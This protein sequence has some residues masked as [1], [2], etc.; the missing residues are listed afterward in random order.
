MRIR[1]M[2]GAINPAFSFRRFSGDQD[3]PDRTDSTNPSTTNILFPSAECVTSRCRD[4]K[5]NRNYPIKCDAITSGPD[6]SIDCR[7]SK[8][9]GVRLDWNKMKIKAES[10]VARCSYRSVVRNW[11]LERR[12]RTNELYYNFA[13]YSQEIILR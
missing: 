5:W 3:S 9:M 1:R 12:L 7:T 6:S 4:R 2:P 13:C 11:N 8:F 10:R